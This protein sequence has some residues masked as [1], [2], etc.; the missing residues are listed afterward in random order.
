MRQYKRLLQV[1]FAEGL[2]TCRRLKLLRMDLRGP[3]EEDAHARNIM[4]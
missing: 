2:K 1:P 3:V 4:A